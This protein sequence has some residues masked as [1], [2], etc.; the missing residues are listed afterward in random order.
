M[1]SCSTNICGEEEKCLTENES[2]DRN[3][4]TDETKQSG[5]ELSISYT[6]PG[7]EESVK[8]SKD[9]VRAFNHIGTKSGA[10]TVS[11]VQCS[12]YKTY[13]NMKEPPAFTDNFKQSVADL[14][15]KTLELQPFRFQVYKIGENEFRTYLNETTERQFDYLF[16]DFI[17]VYGTHFLH[18][19]T[20]V[21]N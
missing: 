8:E 16:T 6:V 12:K 15:T 21:Q 19:V 20:S 5:E 1:S 18:E 2:T 17:S 7:K 14:E 10:L 3:E 11:K 9:V 4:N 13:F